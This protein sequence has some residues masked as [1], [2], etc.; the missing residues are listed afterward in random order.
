MLVKEKHPR[1][2]KDAW[3]VDIVQLGEL[4]GIDRRR[5]SEKL[6]ECPLHRIDSAGTNGRNLY[7]VEEAVRI[8]FGREG[9][10]SPNDRKKRLEADMVELKLLREQGVL[11]RP[12]EMRAGLSTLA[13]LL[14]KMGD[15]L[16][17]RFGPEAQKIVNQ[18][19]ESGLSQVHAA[20]DSTHDQLSSDA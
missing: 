14:R 15:I 7:A 9:E 16:G 4:L 1:T 19:L 18:T 11:V 17:R 13:E 6:K 5:L 8:V 10:E 12:D 2:K 20:I 3:F